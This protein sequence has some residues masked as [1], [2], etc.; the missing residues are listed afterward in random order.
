MKNVNEYIKDHIFE[1]WRK[2]WTY[3]W[4]SQ[5]YTQLEQLTCE[6]KAWKKFRSDRDSNP[7]PLRYRCSAL[8]TELSSLWE[9]HILWVHNIPVE[10]EE[11]KW[12]YERSYIWTAEKDMNLWLVSA[13]IH[14]TW[15]VVKS[16]SVLNN[17]QALI[18]QP[19][20]FAFSVAFL[21]RNKSPRGLN[22]DEFCLSLQWLSDYHGESR[23]GN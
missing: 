19:L 12:I 10:I 11:C 23:K 18:L 7:W 6:I 21:S 16:R 8:P 13:V 14:I 5:L 17:F 22:A 20:T 4:S 2:I 3:G 1:L 15:A 9:L